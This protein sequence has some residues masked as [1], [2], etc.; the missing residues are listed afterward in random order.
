MSEPED[1]A[2][3]QQASEPAPIDETETAPAP[4]GGLLKLPTRPSREHARRQLAYWLLVL[5]TILVVVGCV[6]WLAHGTDRDRMQNYA[7]LFSPIVTLLGTVLG[8]Y[9]SSHDND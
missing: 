9:F 3:Q 7:I 2:G 1:A 6:G 5:L 8:F 4:K